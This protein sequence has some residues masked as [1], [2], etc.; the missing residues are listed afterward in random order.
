M[1]NKQAKYLL[2]TLKLKFIKILI[3]TN[4]IYYFLPSLLLCSTKFDMFLFNY[5][6]LWS[7][8]RTIS[9]KPTLTPTP[10]HK[11]SVDLSVEGN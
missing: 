7:A 10:A 5:S 1:N 9:Q 4:F 2:D 6:V 8:H 3:S 11:H